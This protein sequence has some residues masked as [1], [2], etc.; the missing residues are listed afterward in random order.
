MG[1]WEQMLEISGSSIDIRV[2]TSLG[3][4]HRKMKTFE[5]GIVYFERAL[6][7]DHKNFYALFGLADCYRG[8][9]LQ[10][11]SLV[12]WQQ[13][14]DHDPANKVILTRVGDAYRHI[15]TLD[16]AENYYQK[17]LNIEFDLYAIL[18]LALINKERENYSEAIE[19]LYGL[20]KDDP[21]NYRLYSEI[22]D[23]HMRLSQPKLALEVL[24]SFQKLGI[25]NN[26]ITK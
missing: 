19:S 7:L 5:Q 26:Y 25:R 12:F 13:I 9:N 1:Y 24:T 23:C 11:K 17:A 16:E 21:K 14:L 15:G 20:M 8:L 4:C 10:E 3:N 6:E 2:L 22:A 18:G